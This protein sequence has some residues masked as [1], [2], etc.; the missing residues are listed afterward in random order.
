MNAK[1][2]EPDDLT[3][4]EKAERERVFARVKPEVESA[5]DDEVRAMLFYTIRVSALRRDPDWVAKLLRET[6]DSLERGRVH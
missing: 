2:T 6:A 1:K 3:P 5:S 4:A